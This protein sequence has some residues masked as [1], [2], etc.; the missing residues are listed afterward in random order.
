[1]THHILLEYGEQ[2]LDE[3]LVEEYPPVLNEE[4]IRVWEEVF[5]VATTIKELHH[6]D[7][8]GKDIRG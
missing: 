7:I 2:D 5:S 4:I 1:M 6:P 8:E 3:W